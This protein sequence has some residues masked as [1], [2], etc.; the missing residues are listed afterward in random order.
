MK[1][2]YLRK[3]K[4]TNALNVLVIFIIIIGICVIYLLKLFNDKAIPQFMNY[5]EVETKK[6]VTSV[7][8]ETVIE[9]TYKDSKLDNLF[10][11]TK[12]KDDNI[13][14]IDFNPNYVNQILVNTYKEV[15]R[16]LTYLERGQV[17]KLNLS[18]MKFPNKKGIIYEL[19]SGIIFNNVILN[20]IFPKIPVKIDLVGNLF[21][22]LDTNIKSY[23]INNALISIN[24]IVD[25][26]VKILLPFISKSVKISESIPVLMK[27]IEGNVPSYYFDGFLSNP[28][29]SNSVD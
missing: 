7:I 28:I 17:D 26:E 11:I 8:N 15:E 16:N 20:N 9:Q 27:I 25:V 6:I 29:V 13:K 10:I 19:P 14:A 3:R 4:K 21:C 1:R 12:D 23:G 24:I 2:M 5:S 18:N 22:R